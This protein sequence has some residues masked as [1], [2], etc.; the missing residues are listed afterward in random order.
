[1]PDPIS[2]SFTGPYLASALLFGYLFG[3]IPFGLILTRRAGIG[4][5]RA[6]GSGNVGATNVL[7]HGGKFLAM[8]TLILDMLKGSIPVLLAREFGPDMAVMAGTGAFFGH[9]YP[10]WLKFRGGKGVATALGVLLIL[11]W[12][13]GIL[14]CSTWIIIT[15]AFRFSS[16]ASLTAFATAPIYAWIFSDRQCLEF[17]LFLSLFIFLRHYRNIGRLTQ[18]R[19]SRLNLR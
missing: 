17:T 3:S 11:S 19:E 14:A 1:M 5:I 6:M 7:R 12:P 10:V 15:V 9:L 4:D 13:V 18:G 8:C 16:L 2:W